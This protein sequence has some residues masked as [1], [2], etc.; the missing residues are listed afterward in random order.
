MAYSSPQHAP[1]P[2]QPSRGRVPWWVWPAGGGVLVVAVL[3][4][5]VA[6]VPDTG[7]QHTGGA[8]ASRAAKASAKKAS[9]GW[10]PTAVAV[11]RAQ[12]GKE[13]PFK[14]PTVNGFVG[15]DADHPGA[16]IFNPGS[17]PYLAKP[18]AI[19]GTALDAGYPDVPKRIWLRDPLIPDAQARMDVGPLQDRAPHGCEP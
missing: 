14:A 12:L 1:N 11:T 13:W 4:V 2:Q 18:F 9:V 19:N 15:C 5:G 6:V 3:G 16:I 8:S 10:P 7:G 17:G